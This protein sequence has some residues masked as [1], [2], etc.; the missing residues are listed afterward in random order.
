[1]SRVR[2]IDLEKIVGEMQEEI[3]ELRGHLTFVVSVLIDVVDQL[4]D[5]DE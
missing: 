5:S 3:D 2:V 4:E 1:M